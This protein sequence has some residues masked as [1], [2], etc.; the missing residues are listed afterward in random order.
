MESIREQMQGFAI[1]QALKYVEGNPEE[2]LPKLM[3][4][5]DRFSPADWYASQ[6]S[7]VREV[8]EKKNNWYQLI[9]KLYELSPNVR[10][11]FFQNFLFNASLKGSAIQNEA[12]EREGCN[13]PWAILLD[14]TSACNMHCTG[15]WA[16]EYG[17]LLNLSYEDIDSI[18]RQG[19]ELGV[20]MYIYT[21]GE[22][23]VRKADL[24][25]LCEAHPDCEFLSFTNG[26][27]IDEA[28]CNE[29]LRVG[30]F[31]PAISLEGF[32][33]AN[34]SRRGEGAFGKVRDAMALLKAHRLPFGVSTCYT[35][36]NFEDVTSEAFFDYMV[37]SGALF[38]WFFHY[39]PVG[40]DAAP[41]LLP[42]PEQRAEVYRRIRAFR[43]SKP[44]FTLDFQNDAEYVG[45]CIAGG[46]NYLHINAKGD[47]EPCVFIHYSNV[48]I[49]DCTLLDALKSPIFM[50]YHDEQPFNGNMLRPCP[51]LE[52]PECLRRMVKE[53]GAVNTDYQSPESV[54][55]LCDKTTPYAERWKPTADALWNEG[56][57]RA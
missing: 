34:D 57:K 30:N 22:P 28:F 47:V 3:A 35:S 54:D 53:T 17:H 55:H 52:N 43:S 20:Y 40:N 23:L 37:D 44:I 15:C 38:A 5:V 11:A 4:L 36:R 10:R 27:L 16:A 21:G 42:A 29:M 32:E 14:P 6:R 12:K 50:A 13:V 9:L 48:N 8:I 49:H 26:T 1:K 51:M 45:G 56:R 2:N 41:E 39:M 18:I 46:R 33:E 31:V 7:A 19:K 24:I 25:R